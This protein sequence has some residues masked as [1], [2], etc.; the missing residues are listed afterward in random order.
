[1][2][3]HGEKIDRNQ[4]IIN[5][6]TVYF[7]H[8]NNSITRIMLKNYLILFWKRWKM[9]IVEYLLTTKFQANSVE[10]LTP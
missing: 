8:I 7:N 3:Q 2:R 10:P 6:I 5:F 4:I 9:K 1:M